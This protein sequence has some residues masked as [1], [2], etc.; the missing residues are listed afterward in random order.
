MD[1]LRANL[2]EITF[3]LCKL[4]WLLASL[5]NIIYHFKC[6]PGVYFRNLKCLIFYGRIYFNF[7]C[8]TRAFEGLSLQYKN[9]YLD[10]I[11]RELSLLLFSHS[12]PLYPF[13]YAYRYSGLAGT[14]NYLSTYYQ[15][16]VVCQI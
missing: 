1:S 8:H 10:M 11:T 5:E 7:Q 3:D 6:H 14:L 2:N 16:W 13:S 15:T 9:I 4:L 12:K